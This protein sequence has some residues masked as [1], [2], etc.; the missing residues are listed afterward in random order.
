[1]ALILHRQ[2]FCPYQQKFLRLISWLLIFML[3]LTSISCSFDFPGAAVKPDQNFKLSDNVSIVFGRLEIF[4]DGQL[5]PA[6]TTSISMLGGGAAPLSINSIKVTDVSSL[7]REKWSSYRIALQ[8]SI[9]IHT[10]QS[11]RYFLAVL[12]PG[13]Y[14]IGRGDRSIFL[15][16]FEYVPHE[17]KFLNKYLVFDIA[18]K[19]LVYVGTIRINIETEI[20]HIERTPE[21]SISIPPIGGGVGAMAGYSAVELG[22]ETFKL[23]TPPQK[24]EFDFLRIKKVEIVDEK[25]KAKE[26]FHTLY[27]NLDFTNTVEKFIELKTYK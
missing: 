27:P 1:M 13:K 21:K 2:I 9:I 16:L 4:K 11:D 15:L 6:D 23:F 17:H 26:F 22:K 18:P 7:P 24:K 8:K 25:E 19:S 14:L 10:E 20:I 3:L 5:I 12:P